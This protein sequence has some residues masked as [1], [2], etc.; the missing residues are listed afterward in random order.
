M[1]ISFNVMADRGFNIREIVT[2]ITATF[3]ILPFAKGESL[4][5]KAC[6]I[7]RTIAAVRL[8]MKRAMQR[9]EC[10][11]ILVGVIAATL[12]AVTDQTAFVCA[13]LCTV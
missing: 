2:K 4:S 13:A 1:N 9:L 11:P 12:A 6:A 8:H 5:T 7:T 10:F 3:N